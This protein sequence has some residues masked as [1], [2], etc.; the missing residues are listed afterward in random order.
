MRVKLGDLVAD[1]E[2]TLAIA[3]RCAPLVLETM[4]YVDCRVTDRDGVLYQEPM[5]MEW[6]ATGADANE[7]QPVNQAVLAAV[8]EVL[9]ERARATAL[10]ANRRGNYENARSVLRDIIKHLKAIAPG[11][12][13]VLAIINRLRQDEKEMGEQMDV[14]A[15]KS[16]HF[17]S[18]SRTQSRDETGKARRS[19]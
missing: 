19:V 7:Q 3:I 1:Q 16:H 17:A 6:R 8:A 4:V 12:E 5:R 9:A 2:I 11:N 13:Q 14:M 10:S 18:Y 15:L